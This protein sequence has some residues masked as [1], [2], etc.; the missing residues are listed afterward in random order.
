M[1]KITN[2]KTQDELDYS[3]LLGLQS[4]VFCNGQLKNSDTKELP[5]HWRKLIDER[6]ITVHLTPV[7]ASQELVVKGVQD[8]K[9][10]L[11]AHGGFPIN[12]YY[13]VIAT[14]HEGVDVVSSED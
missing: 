5:E 7:G 13:M 3:G 12:C 11:T 8:N 4:K 10:M 2:P 9:V 1:M 14:L 6:S